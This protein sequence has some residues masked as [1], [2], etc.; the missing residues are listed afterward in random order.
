M[1]VGSHGDGAKP[2]TLRA[3]EFAGEIVS[4]LSNPLTADGQRDVGHSRHAAA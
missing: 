2:A 3:E 1:D 4:D